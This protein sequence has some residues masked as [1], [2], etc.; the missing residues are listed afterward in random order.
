MLDLRNGAPE[1]VAE[2]LRACLDAVTCV[3]RAHAPR[4]HG[5][6][7]ARAPRCDSPTNVATVEMD[8]AKARGCCTALP[9]PKA[10][11]TNAPCRCRCSQT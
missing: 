2:L 6:A 9:S 10:A 4:C 5:R 3:A 1:L 7:H 8:M 11:L